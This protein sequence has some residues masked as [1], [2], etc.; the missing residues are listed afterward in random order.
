MRPIPPTQP[1][2]MKLRCRPVPPTPQSIAMS[3]LTL[4]RQLL[5]PI[6]Q[7]IVQLQR[8]ALADLPNLTFANNSQLIQ[9][10]RKR[11]LNLT[12][13]ANCASLTPFYQNRPKIRSLLNYNSLPTTRQII[14][15]PKS[16]SPTLCLIS[17]MQHKRTSNPLRHSMLNMTFPLSHSCGSSP[18]G[19]STISTCKRSQSEPSPHK[20][21]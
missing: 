19:H 7:Q 9:T 10:S 17:L 16:K 14:S 3:P 21:C 4:I 13:Q 11:W 5:P 15:Q 18:T 1:H 20:L 6:Q 8:T 12:Q 2:R